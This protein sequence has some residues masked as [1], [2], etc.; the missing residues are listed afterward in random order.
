M[1]GVEVEEARDMMAG[2]EGTVPAEAQRLA[3]TLGE[4]G[5]GRGK[6]S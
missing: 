6:K 2:L 1:T 4:R 3:E 5:G